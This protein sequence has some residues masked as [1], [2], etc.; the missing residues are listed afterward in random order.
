MRMQC[1]DLPGI[2]WQALCCNQAFL[3]T[4][5]Q[6]QT[7]RNPGKKKPNK[8][9]LQLRQKSIPTIC[10][11]SVAVQNV[12]RYLGAYQTHVLNRVWLHHLSNEL[13]LTL[14]TDEYTATVGWMQLFSACWNLKNST[15][16]SQS[17]CNPKQCKKSNKLF[18]HQK[19]KN[20]FVLNNFCGQSA[21]QP[22][23]SMPHTSQYKF[24]SKQNEEN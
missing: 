11:F 15:R 14:C 23:I 17:K 20:W 2:A 22:N 6:P 9:K 24:L 8:Q 10:L 21:L 18:F 5:S 1:L 13:G 4:L 7:C 3:Q 12:L 16:D 19:E